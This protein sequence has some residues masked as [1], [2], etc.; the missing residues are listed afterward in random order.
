MTPLLPVDVAVAFDPPRVMVT[1]PEETIVS[2]IGVSDGVMTPSVPVERKVEFEPERVN[3]VAVEEM[4]TSS[5]TDP[6]TLAFNDTDA[7]G[8]MTPAVPEEKKVEK[9]S[10]TVTLPSPPRDGA[11]VGVTIPSVPVEA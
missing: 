9:T 10:I 4:T 6:L 2:K 7:L 11:G 8:G 3:V 1:A 5:L